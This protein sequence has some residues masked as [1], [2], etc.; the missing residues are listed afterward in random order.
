[1]KDHHRKRERYVNCS[2]VLND[3]REMADMPTIVRGTGG[4][5]RL[6]RGNRG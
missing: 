5:K 4:A 3:G 6:F 1:M 2:H